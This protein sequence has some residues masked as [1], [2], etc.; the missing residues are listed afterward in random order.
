MIFTAY[1]MIAGLGISSCL[2]SMEEEI[3]DKKSISLQRETRTDSK[4]EKK[5]G[6]TKSLDLEGKD[7]NTPAR[8][9]SFKEKISKVI[10]G[11]KEKKNHVSLEN[12]NEEIEDKHSSRIRS[13]SVQMGMKRESSND[14]NGS[15]IDYLS[16]G[17]YD[18][19]PVNFMPD[20]QP[21]FIKK[22]FDT[23]SKAMSRRKGFKHQFSDDNGIDIKYMSPR[24]SREIQF[25][26]SPK[27][28]TPVLFSLDGGGIRGLLQISVI[29]GI[30]EYFKKPI[31]E[32]ADV[33]IGTSIGGINA[34]ALGYGL[35]AEEVVD[36]YSPENAKKIFQKNTFGGMSGPK[37]S[38]KGMKKLITE[39]VGP[40]K[41]LSDLKTN[42]C[43]T[44]YDT[45]Q[46]HLKIFHSWD[47][48]DKDFNLIDI[49]LATSAAPT[50]FK[51]AN[52]N[53]TAYLD[54]GI[55][56]NDPILCGVTTVKTNYRKDPFAVSIGTGQ[57]MAPYFYDDLKNAGY[58]SWAPII[59]D[60]CMRAN[61]DK[62]GENA[63]ALLPENYYN[64][65]QMTLNTENS[66]LDNTAEANLKTLPIYAN[67]IIE[68]E[69]FESVMR[70]LDKV[71][72]KNQELGGK[73]AVNLTSKLN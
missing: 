57:R 33:I 71:L 45:Q 21:S 49:A 36:F 13:V 22:K 27:E 60:L 38:S 6:Y 19:Q 14:S 69:Y 66:A 61:S 55:G 28:Y 23:V 10:H 7:N 63:K 44:A 4:E 47:V 50:F 31:S 43:I 41:K 3:P 65:L 46:S 54:G 5:N 42:V 15:N 18:A 20:R 73:S 24:R 59:A 67:R 40:D 39:K 29:T 2:H 32:I 56:A 51:P 26:D 16:S 11:K 12:P 58:V 35:K 64:R 34:M 62:D 1:L 72:D 53:N 37:Y 8:R 25:F 70:R 48:H 68:G 17:E 9:P 30:E 52:F